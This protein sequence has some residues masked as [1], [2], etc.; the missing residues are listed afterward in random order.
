MIRTLLCFSL[1]LVL[2]FSAGCG[3]NKT[4]AVIPTKFEP[5]PT[6]GPIG[7]GTGDK[8]PGVDVPKK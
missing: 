2:S 5:P 7:V 1:L 4:E 3:N 6:S 8:K